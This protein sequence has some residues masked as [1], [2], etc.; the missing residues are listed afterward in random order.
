M[1]WSFHC[2]FVC[3]NNAPAEPRNGRPCMGKSVFYLFPEISNVGYFL[4]WS[5]WSSWSQ[6]SQTCDLGTRI[7]SRTCTGAICPTSVETREEPC[8]FEPCLGKNT[9]TLSCFL[10]FASFVRVH[11]NQTSWR[12]QRYSISS[13]GRKTPGW[14]S[15]T[16]LYALMYLQ[17]FLLGPFG[18]IAPKAVTMAWER[19]QDYARDPNAKQTHRGELNIAPT[20]RVGLSG[21]VIE[22]CFPFTVLSEE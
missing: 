21:K 1:L 8:Q 10:F 9:N 19:D 17:A 11:I 22:Y 18:P 2:Q 5:D 20:S 16:F 6:C 13:E 7:S 3:R 4:E 15:A 14:K 12:R